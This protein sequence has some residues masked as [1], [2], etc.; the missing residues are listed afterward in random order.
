MTTESSYARLLAWSENADE[1]LEVKR[2]AFGEESWTIA[3]SVSE[4]V[5]FSAHGEGDTLDE[6]AQHVINQL[7]QVGV[8]IE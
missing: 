2:N 6:A 8:A 5:A 3:A 4:P 7:R 1:P